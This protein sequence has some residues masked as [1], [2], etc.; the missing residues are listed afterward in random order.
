MKKIPLYIHVPF[1]RSKCSY[2]AFYSCIH[3]TIDDEI[4]Y[5]KELKLQIQYYMKLTRSDQF[6]TV[7]IGGGTPS[8]LSSYI[9][10]ELF[11]YLKT[12]IDGDLIEFT[13][14]CN[15]E[16]V[17]DDLILMLNNSP[18]N[19]ISLGVQSFQNDVLNKSG[20][21][22]D[23]I[24]IH[25]AIEKIKTQWSGRFSIDIITGLPGQTVAGQL[26]DIK[27]AVESGVDHISCYSLII[28]ENTP[29]AD[30][31]DKL[32]DQDT[33]DQMWTNCHE[34]LLEKGFNHYEVS[35]YS[36]S[37][38]ESIHNMQYWSMNEYIGCGPGAV[39]MIFDNGIKR[40][41][42]SHDFKAYLTGE[43]NMWAVK[44]E[45]IEP[46]DFLFE[47]YMMGLRTRKGINREVF[48]NRFNKYPEELIASTIQSKPKDTFK[49]NKRTFSLKDESRLFMNPILMEIY[50]ELAMNKSEIELNWP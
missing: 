28:E 22:S 24:I 23:D 18:V 35:N 10:Q 16:D 26:N 36:K 27:K 41:S 32:P 43:E 21:K 12:Y 9:L 31:Q 37:G 49:L 25:R 48:Y 29:M 4:Q 38:Y 30:N 46:V 20:R 13:M 8:L 45:S 7:Y 1:C 17:S 50:D 42:N 34:Y 39:S 5:L 19:R 15:P 14:E 2:C 44:K 6:E 47:N 40:I 33:E 11:T 3:H